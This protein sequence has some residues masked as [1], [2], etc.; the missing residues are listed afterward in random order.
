MRVIPASCC[1]KEGRKIPSPPLETAIHHLAYHR[2]LFAMNTLPTRHRGPSLSGD[3]HQYGIPVLNAHNDRNPTSDIHGYS[4]TNVGNVSNSYNTINVRVDGESLSIQ[5][6]L[7]PL[8]PD[9]RHR[10]VSNRRFDGVGD[11]V[12]QRNEFGSWCGNQ[13]GS[14]DPTL[15]CYGGQGVGKTFIRYY[16]IL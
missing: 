12:L 5:A 14:E 3:S 2:T 16:A 7:S 4:N 11:W 15:L 6:W 1:T 13:D 9:R 8:E 10:D